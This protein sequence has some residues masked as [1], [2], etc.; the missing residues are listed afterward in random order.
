MVPLYVM[1]FENW[2]RNFI[3]TLRM[4]Y[5]IL[6]EYVYMSLHCNYCSHLVVLV[7]VN[8]MLVALHVHDY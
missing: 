8:V 6:V 1:F 4:C 3:Y 5:R 7:F 2:G